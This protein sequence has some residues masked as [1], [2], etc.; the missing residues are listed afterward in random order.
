[1]QLCQWLKLAVL[2]LT[3]VAL[4]ESKAENWLKKLVWNMGQQT[5]LQA[6]WQPVL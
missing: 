5:D 3:C 2:L 4:D 1:M 6:G